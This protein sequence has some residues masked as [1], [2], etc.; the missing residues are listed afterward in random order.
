MIH[1]QKLWPDD[2]SHDAWSVE[3]LSADQLINSLQ[4]K[5][6]VD[7]KC[8]RRSVFSLYFSFFSLY[9]WSI[10]CSHL[11]LKFWWIINCHLKN[12]IINFWQDFKSQNLTSTQTLALIY[13]VTSAIWSTGIKET[14]NQ[15]H[16]LTRA[17][18]W[19]TDFTQG[20][21]GWTSERSW[22]IY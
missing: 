20:S 6:I 10:L 18:V 17:D 7:W 13:F 3:L 16:K 11:T 5:A 9:M 12:H 14:V 21:S 8:S 2:S 1:T 15:I 19:L 4:S 22:W